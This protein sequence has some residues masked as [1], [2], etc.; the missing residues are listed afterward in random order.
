MRQVNIKGADE[1]DVYEL[2]KNCVESF[3]EDRKWLE[4]FEDELR[5]LIAKFT[6]EDKELS[7]EIGVTKCYT[8]KKIEQILFNI[9]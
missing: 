1:L 9:D 2:A 4:Q 3:W 5:V 6:K 8:W 7:E